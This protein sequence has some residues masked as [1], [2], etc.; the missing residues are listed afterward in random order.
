MKTPGPQIAV[1]RALGYAVLIFFALVFIAP[2]LITLITSFKT[3]TDAS[4]N[5]LARSPTP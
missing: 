2:F 5:P 1:R 4:L 3:D